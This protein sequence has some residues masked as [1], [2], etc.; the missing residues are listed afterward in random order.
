MGKGQL[1]SYME[2]GKLKTHVSKKKKKITTDWM[3]VLQYTQNLT[4]NL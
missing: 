2:L 3:T 1:F 4:Q